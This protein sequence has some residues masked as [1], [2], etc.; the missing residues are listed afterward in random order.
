[1]RFSLLK[2]HRANSPILIHGAETRVKIISSLMQAN[3]H[4]LV[5]WRTWARRF[6]LCTVFGTEIGV[7]DRRKAKSML[8]WFDLG[9]LF[10]ENGRTVWELVC[11]S[12]D[13]RRA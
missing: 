3:G 11:E 8:N 10:E 5:T 6:S 2:M 7:L 4:R 12:S 1:M 13:S 9:I